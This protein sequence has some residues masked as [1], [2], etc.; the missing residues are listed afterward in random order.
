[1]KNELTNDMF[2]IIYWILQDYHPVDNIAK[3]T[4]EI[5]VFCFW[6]ILQIF[7]L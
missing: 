6:N 2:Y 1:M 5:N 4:H 7:C 3:M